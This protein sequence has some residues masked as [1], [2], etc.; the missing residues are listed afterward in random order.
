MLEKWHTK[1]MFQT[2]EQKRERTRTE[3]EQ[4]KTKAHQLGTYIDLIA[5]ESKAL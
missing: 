2:V 1:S 5:Q 4:L 3:F